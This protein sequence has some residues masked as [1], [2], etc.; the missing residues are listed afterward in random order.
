MSPQQPV[1][2]SVFGVL[3]EY[4]G[5]AWLNN[6]ASRSTSRSAL[7]DGEAGYSSR[8]GIDAL[9]DVLS[10]S[11]TS[12]DRRHADVHAVRDGRRSR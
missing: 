2:P 8:L 4:G 1:G 12:G 10:D 3:V 11:A 7:F 9:A 6:L 5:Y